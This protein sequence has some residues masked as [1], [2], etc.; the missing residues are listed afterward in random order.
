MQA[1]H[2][3]C[4]GTLLLG[5]KGPTFDTRVESARAGRLRNLL[6]DNGI[7]VS[8]RPPTSDPALP[9]TSQYHAL[10][11]LLIVLTPSRRSAVPGSLPAWPPSPVENPAQP[12][13]VG[14]QQTMLP[15]L[16]GSV[17]ALTGYTFIF[18]YVPAFGIT[19][20]AANYF[21]GT[22]SDRYG[23]KPVLL[24]GWLFTVPVPVMLIA[25][26]NWWWVVAANILL[27]INQGLTWSTTV[28]MKCPGR[29]RPLWRTDDL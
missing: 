25:A 19:K 22:F 5:G 16:A 13:M 29:C 20:A 18:T 8:A 2:C 4:S 3:R 23:R 21:A 27:G 1:R 28:V 17:F 15:L 24:V 10:R 11:T 26:P 12:G 9:R 7:Q 6:S 14:Q